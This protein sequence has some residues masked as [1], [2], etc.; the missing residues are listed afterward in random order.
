MLPNLLQ[1]VQQ[2]LGGAQSTSA[3]TS[4]RCLLTIL[5]I[6]PAPAPCCLC[7]H[8]LV[9]AITAQLL[10]G[11]QQMLGGAQS[12]GTSGV[13]LTL[14]PF[15]PAPALKTDRNQILI[16]GRFQM[17]NFVTTSAA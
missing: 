7:N 5:R 13:L 12:T 16:F 10:Q 17:Q 15:P 11:V 4:G 8:N 6:S 9:A 3:G 2:M 1:G 14:L